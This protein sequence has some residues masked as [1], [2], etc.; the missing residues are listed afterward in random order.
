MTPVG[1]GPWQIGLPRAF[2]GYVSKIAGVVP[3]PP[4]TRTSPRRAERSDL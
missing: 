2:G 1:I 4:R 3:D